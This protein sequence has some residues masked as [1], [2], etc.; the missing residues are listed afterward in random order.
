MI[1]HIEEVSGSRTLARDEEVM[2]DDCKLSILIFRLIYHKISFFF[3]WNFCS[4][5]NILK[6]LLISRSRNVC[7]VHYGISISMSEMKLVDG[8]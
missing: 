1:L 4:S 5:V 6:K 3:S 2:E 8:N 7:C